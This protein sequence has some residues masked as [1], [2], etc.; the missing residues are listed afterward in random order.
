MRGVDRWQ[1]YS[2]K[3]RQ[4]SSQEKVR[5]DVQHDER[6]A[7]GAAGLAAPESVVL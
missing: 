6:V 1:F 5:T 3:V 7:R 4:E 2:A